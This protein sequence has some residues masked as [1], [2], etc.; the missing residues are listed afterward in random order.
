LERILE[1][2]LFGEQFRFKVGPDDKYAEKAIQLLV[3][4]INETGDISSL[5]KNDINRFAQL[6]L[7]TLNICNDYFDLKDKHDQ[8]LQTIKDR[9]SKIVNKIDNNLK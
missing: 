9:S 7:A 4:K 1:I 5:P 3:R 2:E 8:L 6:L